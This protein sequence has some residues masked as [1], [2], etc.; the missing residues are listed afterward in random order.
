M[1]SSTA[2]TFTIIFGLVAAIAAY[3]YLFG[4]P[5]EAKRKMEETAL[6]TMGENKAS[7]M[8]KGANH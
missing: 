4:I 3:F 8:M 1:P 2:V 5:P 7:Y 6:D